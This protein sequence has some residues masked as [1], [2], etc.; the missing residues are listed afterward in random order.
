MVAWFSAGGGVDAPLPAEFLQARTK[1]ECEALLPPAFAALRTAMRLRGADTL[2]DPV[3]DP[4]KAPAAALDLGDCTMPFVLLKKG[5]KPANGWPLYLCLHGGGGNDK[6]EGPHGWSVNTREWEAQKRLFERV[7]QAPGL[8]FIPRMADDRRGRWWFAHN[9]R[10]FDEVIRKAILFEDVDPDRVYLMGISEGGYGAIRFA[11]NRPDRFAATGGMAAAE[12]L[13]TSPP[14]NMRNVA[15]RID[16]GEKDSMFDRI[17]L[18]RRMGERLAE[19]RQADPAGYD[20]AVNV[21]AGRGHGIDYSLTPKWLADKVRSTR[22]NVVNWRIVPF[23]GQVELRHYW[24]GL[25]S[26]P[27]ETPVVVRAEWSGNRLSIDARHEHRGEDGETELLPVKVGRLRVL[28]DDELADLGAPIE[29]VVNGRARG[30][31]KVG[32]TLLTLLQTLLERWDPR[33]AFTAE[34][35]VDLGEG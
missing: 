15:M 26:R 34:F 18:A 21:Q 6:A 1:Q 22:P 28:V 32:R 24:L 10:A 16:I 35:E 29:L 2:P 12:P 3:A 31:V 25:R 4:A 5:D 7:Y 13:G 8:Y 23:D 30:D 11:G 17:G 33:G 19:L 9:Q 14:E 20:F 27:E